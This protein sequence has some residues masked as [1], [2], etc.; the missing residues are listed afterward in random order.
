MNYSTLQMRNLKTTKINLLTLD[1]I[2][3]RQGPLWMTDLPDTECLKM[4]PYCD[5]MLQN[6][7]YLDPKGRAK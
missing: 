2:R 7:S 1:T 5:L 4:P 6:I 3:N